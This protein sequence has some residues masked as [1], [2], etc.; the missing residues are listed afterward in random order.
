MIL[1]LSGAQDTPAG[2]KDWIDIPFAYRD[3]KHAT[4]AKTKLKEGFFDCFHDGWQDFGEPAF[5][6]KWDCIIYFSGLRH[7]RL[8][9]IGDRKGHGH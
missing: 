1:L 6:S 5:E 4:L 9:E 3:V 2:S 8:E 7:Q